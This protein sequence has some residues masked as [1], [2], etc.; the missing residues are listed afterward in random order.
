PV[1][2]IVREAGLRLFAVVD[3]VD[4][5]LDLLLY[6]V[7]DC[8]LDLTVVFLGVNRLPFAASLHQV[9]QGLRAGETARVRCE[10]SVF[11]VL[12]SMLFST[13]LQGTLYFMSAR[14]CRTSSRQIQVLLDRQS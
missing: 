14:I 11:A 1:T 6:Y 3:D 10:D 12:H 5:A 7:R 13:S 2:D 4:A 8:R 9:E